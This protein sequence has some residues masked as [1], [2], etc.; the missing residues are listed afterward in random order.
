[1]Q[2]PFEN[3]N[4]VL[5]FCMV[6]LDNR[7]FDSLRHCASFSLLENFLNYYSWIPFSSFVGYTSTRVTISI[8]SSRKIKFFSF[9][10]SDAPL[11]TTLVPSSCKFNICIFMVFIFFSIPLVLLTWVISFDNFP[12]RSYN[13][14]SEK[15]LFFPAKT[16][17]VK[18]KHKAVQVCMWL[19]FL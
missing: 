16:N 4:T 11:C 8:I 7:Q 13:V 5:I 14:S 1:M 15:F 19:L 17:F 10:S 18:K 2:K 6:F 9:F 3:F 12:P